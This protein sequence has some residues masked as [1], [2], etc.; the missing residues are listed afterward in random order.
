LLFIGESAQSA[1]EL[2]LNFVLPGNWNEEGE[3]TVV[4]QIQRLMHTVRGRDADEV[5]HP[6]TDDFSTLTLQWIETNLGHMDEFSGGTVEDI[7]IDLITVLKNEAR[8]YG[9]TMK[10]LE[11][12]T[13]EEVL[14]LF[15][16]ELQD[17]YEEL[18]AAGDAGWQNVAS[19]YNYWRGLLDTF[20]ANLA[21]TTDVQDFVAAELG[22]DP[23]DPDVVEATVVDFNEQVI[24]SLG[25]DPAAVDF[26]NM[27][28]EEST[29]FAYLQLIEAY[30][31]AESEI[32]ALLGLSADAPIP[33]PETSVGFVSAPYAQMSTQ[34]GIRYSELLVQL[35]ALEAQILRSQNLALAFEMQYDDTRPDEQLLL[36]VASMVA[37]PIDWVLTL[38]EV[39][40]NLRDGDV[41]SAMLNTALAVTP[42]LAGWMDDVALAGRNVDSFELPSNYGGSLA[43]R[44]LGWTPLPVNRPQR[45]I[46]SA[47]Q[48]WNQFESLVKAGQLP[49]TPQ[50]FEIFLSRYRW[51]RQYGDGLDDVEVAALFYLNGRLKDVFVGDTRG[52]VYVDP[53][54]GGIVVHNHPSGAP[55]SPQDIITA[56]NYGSSEIRS[57]HPRYTNTLIIDPTQID[58]FNALSESQK[59]IAAMRINAALDQMLR[60]GTFGINRRSQIIVNVPGADVSLSVYVQFSPPGGW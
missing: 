38:G 55:I 20:G 7:A 5:T 10:S 23:A 8:A 6:V 28:L 27:G 14:L 29:W 31:G 46:R 44:E 45:I 51:M 26:Q 21:L 57:V 52:M 30:Q 54:P 49:N 24:Q 33:I 37:E 17:R 4:Q 1:A 41:G 53:L 40:Q 60:Y 9:F 42:M 25:I 32:R 12:K 34:E 39:T 11:N 47:D 18:V 36:M 58:A 16:L 43:Q 59:M 19:D 15:M 50:G 48:V 3:A 2:F 56:F 22:V 13:A 35:N